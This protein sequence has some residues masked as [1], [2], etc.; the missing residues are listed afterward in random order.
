MSSTGVPS[1]ASSPSTSTASPSTRTMRQVVSPIRLG[2]F[3]PRWAKMPT[4]GQS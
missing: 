4:S 2:R 3:L 1:I